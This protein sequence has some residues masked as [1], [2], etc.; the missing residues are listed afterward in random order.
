MLKE[1]GVAQKPQKSALVFSIKAHSF[2][3]QAHRFT[4]LAF[5]CVVSSCIADFQQWTTEQYQ[6]HMDKVSEVSKV[7][8]NC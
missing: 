6:N 4:F 3:F 2:D 5:M 7:T 8:F 1:R